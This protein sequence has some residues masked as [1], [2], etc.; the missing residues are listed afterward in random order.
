MSAIFGIFTGDGSTP[1]PLELQRLKVHLARRGPDASAVWTEPGV[2]FGNCQLRTTPESLH[3]SMPAGDVEGTCCITADTRLDNRDE[4]IGELD[5]RQASAAE[6]PDS[7]VI[8][9]AY[10]KWGESCPARLLGDF[11][12]ALWNRRTRTLFC[13]RDPFGVKPFYYA[14]VGPRFAFCSCVDGLLQLDWIPRRLNER[15]LASHLTTFFGDTAA[16]F[17]A[18]ILRLPPAHTLSRSGGA[19]RLTRYWTLSPEC[20]TRFNSEEEYIEAFRSLFQ[21]AVR[22]RLRSTG[23]V[24]SMLSGGLDSS[25]ISAVA[26]RLVAEE[27]RGALASLSAVFDE[28]P[29]SNER[30]Y[31]DAVVKR[32]GF[33]PSYLAADQCDP[34][35]APAEVAGTQAEVHV[36]A[37]M[38]LNWGLYGVARKR[39]IRVVLDGFD[40]DSTISH[41]VSYLLELAQANRWLELSRLVPAAARVCGRSAP[42]LWWAYAWHHGISRK[43]PPA[44]SRLGRGA[45][46]RWQCWRRTTTENSGNEGLLDREFVERV[47]LREYRAS[48]RATALP[49][50]RTERESHYQMLM[51]GVMPATLEMLDQAAAPFGIELRFPFWDRRLIEFCLGLPPRFKIRDGS[52]RWILRKAMEGILPREV[53]W[54]RGKSNIGHAFKHCLFKHGRSTLAQAAATARARLRPYVSARHLDASLRNFL[55]RPG[56]QEA[57]FLW[58]M[59]NLSLWLEKSGIR[60]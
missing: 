18:D 10:R 26:G 31:I 16:T 8:L 14:Q 59:A 46:R 25:S 60:T 53:Q 22:T 36:A 23:K 1:D 21:E 28:V 29:R 57:L 38:F 13:A 58:Q 30:R 9:E 6:I 51:W 39:G 11:A 37:N 41:G 20:E 12:F 44:V 49:P 5:L 50:A 42:G 7:T 32:G 56:D 40:G 2:A 47:G 34:F 43:I 15:R 17:Y 55:A 33:E 3:E 4:L 24:G 45:A 19:V 35:L 52:T 27:G 54:R 48:L